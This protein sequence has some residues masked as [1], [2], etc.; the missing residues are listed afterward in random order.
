MYGAI[1]R[2]ISTATDYPS[3]L[4]QDI[5]A[6]GVIPPINVIPAKAGIQHKTAS[7]AGGFL[8]SQS[9]CLHTDPIP[10][11]LTAAQALT[12]PIELIISVDAVQLTGTDFRPLDVIIAVPIEQHH[13]V[14]P[15]QAATGQIETHTTIRPAIKTSQHTIGQS[16]QRRIITRR[17]RANRHRPCAAIVPR[18]CNPQRPRITSAIA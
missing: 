2:T 11:D 18:A 6:K 1:H 7:A 3:Q 14:R 8:L 16:Y 9:L 10:L 4:S 15:R 5:L 12:L 17:R 13:I